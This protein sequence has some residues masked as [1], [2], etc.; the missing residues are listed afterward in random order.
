MN[1]GQVGGGGEG[2]DEET[3]PISFVEVGQR[4]PD[5]L[6]VTIS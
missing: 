1:E 5:V 3:L 4:L 6:K 2:E